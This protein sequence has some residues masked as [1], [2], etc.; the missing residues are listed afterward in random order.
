M[1]KIK[2]MGASPLSGKIYHGT[3]NTE[4]AL[5]VGKKTDV[6]DMACQAVAEHLYF[7]KKSKVYALKDGRELVMSIEVREAADEQ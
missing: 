5:W 2:H 4:K 1:S 3:L 7:E 6:T